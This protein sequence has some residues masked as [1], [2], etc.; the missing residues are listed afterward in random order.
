M[1]YLK[2]DSFTVLEADCEFNI[3]IRMAKQG[4]VTQESKLLKKLP[5]ELFLHVL[6]YLPGSS[7]LS[8]SLSCKQVR[9]L[10]VTYCIDRII[11]ADIPTFLALLERDL[12]DQVACSEC[13]RLHSME[14]S[15][16]YIPH[17]LQEEIKRLPNCVSADGDT[18]TSSFVD[19]NFSTIVFRMVMKSHAQDSKW[20]PQLLKTLSRNFAKEEDEYTKVSKTEYRIVESSL[21]MRTQIT[22]LTTAWWHF[23]IP[24]KEAI[25]F[26]ICSHLNFQS[27]AFN[28]ES[29]KVTSCYP[30]QDSIVWTTQFAHLMGEARHESSEIQRCRYCRTEFQIYIRHD[31]PHAKM[32]HTVWK[33]LG[34]GP[35][36][37]K[38][39]RHIRQVGDRKVPSR[40]RFVPGEVSSAFEQKEVRDSTSMLYAVEGDEC[41]E[42]AGENSIQ[43]DFSRISFSNW[44]EQL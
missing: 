17:G 40:I 11:G 44:V 33:D 2:Y 10:I 28:T 6:N 30:V 12:P 38:W 7:A 1:E 43:H 15:M 19:G 35:Q 22:F 32:R 8:L 3:P 9:V 16:R 42:Q 34:A 36:D 14:N 27:D 39:K 25:E 4:P 24:K 37:E 21:L 5:L 29:A 18:R 23:P 13:E 41:P 20:T 26:S 31:G